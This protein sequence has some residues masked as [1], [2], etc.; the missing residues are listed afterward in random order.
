MGVYIEIKKERERIINMF[1]ILIEN[2]E[3][4]F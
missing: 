4:E 1:C 3:G 2:C